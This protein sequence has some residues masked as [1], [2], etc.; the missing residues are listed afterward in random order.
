MYDFQ[1]TN[2]DATLIT[3]KFFAFF[4]CFVVIGFWLRLR[5]A[6]NF[7]V[8]NFPINRHHFADLW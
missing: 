1:S 7:M 8:K 4:A 3:L 2:F 6:R 5:R